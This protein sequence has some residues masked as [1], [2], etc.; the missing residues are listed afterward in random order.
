M[1]TTELCSRLYLSINSW[2]KTN[3]DEDMG[4]QTEPTWQAVWQW[5]AGWQAIL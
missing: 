3:R 5:W 2:S 1:D 4:D